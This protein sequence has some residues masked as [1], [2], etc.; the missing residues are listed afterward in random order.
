MSKS[1]RIKLYETCRSGKSD[2]VQAT[3]RR[4]ELPTVRQGLRRCGWRLEVVSGREIVT[5]NGYRL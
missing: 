3:C 5:F 4:S 1:V 2:F